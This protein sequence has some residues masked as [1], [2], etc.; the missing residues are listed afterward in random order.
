MFTVCEDSAIW[1]PSRT[2]CVLNRF[3]RVWLSATLWTVAHQAPLSTGFSRQKYCGGL[4]CPPLGDPPDPGI[5]PTSLRSPAL[6]GVFFTASA[7][8]GA[9]INANPPHF[10]WPRNHLLSPCCPSPEFPHCCQQPTPLSPGSYLREWQRHYLKWPQTLTLLCLGLCGTTAS[11]FFIPLNS[12][13]HSAFIGCLPS[14]GDQIL[15]EIDGRTQKDKT[16]ECVLM[17]SLNLRW[18]KQHSWSSSIFTLFQW[19]VLSISSHLIWV[20]PGLPYSIPCW[21]KL[22]LSLL[23]PSI[24]SQDPISYSQSN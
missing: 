17:V 16:V 11:F 20:F 3:S 9:L 10:E 13:I 22:I 18:P 24:N 19:M 14:P 21:V 12:F 2:L 1:L 5:K 4:P 6:T 8:W 23:S 7:T 15:N